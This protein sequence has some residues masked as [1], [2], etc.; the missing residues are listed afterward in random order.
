[1]DH[2]TETICG[3]PSCKVCYLGFTRKVDPWVLKDRHQAACRDNGTL[4][5]GA[6]PGPPRTVP[7]LEALALSLPTPSS[8][9]QQILFPMRRHLQSIPLSSL[10][11]GPTALPPAS[12]SLCVQ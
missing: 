12:V 5:M 2:V 1:M 8:V 3:Q 10:S 9:P 7:S 11:L 6:Q 4:Q